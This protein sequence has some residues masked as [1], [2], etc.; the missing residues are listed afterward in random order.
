MSSANEGTPLLGLTLALDIDAAAFDVALAK[1]WGYIMTAGVI[2]L[3]L[4]VFALFSP[5]AA[6]EI[7]LAFVSAGLIVAGLLNMCGVFYVEEC[8][9]CASFTSG[10]IQ[11]VLGVLMVTHIFTSLVVLTSIVAGLFMVEGIFRCILALKNRDLQGWGMYLTTGILTLVLSV[12][13][14]YA[15]PTSSEVTLG[16]LLGVNW[17]IYGCLRIVLAMYGRSTAQGLIE[18]SGLNV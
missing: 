7:I 14:W 6:T 3:V 1:E 8:Y 15:M 13:V 10:A 12:I 17:V 16:V 4:G 9:R 5:S 11:L 18:A 2:Q